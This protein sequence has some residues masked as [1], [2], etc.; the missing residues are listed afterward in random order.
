MSLYSLPETR[1]GDHSSGWEPTGTPD[2]SF[3]ALGPKSE[4]APAQRVS[5]AHK[6]HISQFKGAAVTRLQELLTEVQSDPLHLQKSQS[7]N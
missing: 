7:R 2:I 5:Q 3:Q 4:H 1:P 6:A